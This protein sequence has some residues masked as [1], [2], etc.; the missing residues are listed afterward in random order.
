MNRLAGLLG[1]SRD[2]KPHSLSERD[3]YAQIYGERHH[4][5]HHVVYAPK[6]ASNGR[7]RPRDARGRF[8]PLT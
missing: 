2:G 5:S 6:A 4:G 8:L 3:A 1:H 7:K